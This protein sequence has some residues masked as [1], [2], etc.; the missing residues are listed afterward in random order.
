LKCLRE[1]QRREGISFIGNNIVESYSEN[2]Y[3]P[4]I[5]Y[6][7]SVVQALNSWLTAMFTGGL[8]IGVFELM[9]DK[10]QA[11]DVCKTDCSHEK[12]QS[13][14]MANVRNRQVARL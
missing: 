11:I 3:I 13:E 1:R 8:P 2:N 6:E 7:C 10:F 4:V 9:Y 5:S 14:V 12:D